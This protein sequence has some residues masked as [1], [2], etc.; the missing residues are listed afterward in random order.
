MG[1]IT[2]SILDS[3]GRN[4]DVNI[5]EQ[6]QRWDAARKDGHSTAAT[7]YRFRR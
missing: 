5:V 7:P 3:W 4:V 6:I 2:R 1:E